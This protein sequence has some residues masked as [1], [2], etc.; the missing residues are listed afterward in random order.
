MSCTILK[1]VQNGPL[2]KLFRDFYYQLGKYKLSIANKIYF[3]NKHIV[4]LGNM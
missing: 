1:M 4:Y 3:I 2:D